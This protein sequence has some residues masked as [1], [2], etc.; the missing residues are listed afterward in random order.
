M[1]NTVRNLLCCALSSMALAAAA[2]VANAQVPSAQT[3]QAFPGRAEE[4][5]QHKTLVPRSVPGIEVKG[6]GTLNAPSGADK[7]SF[8]LGSLDLEGVTAYREGDL[9]PLYADK[10]GQKITLADLYGI[11]N[12]LT[13][14]YR[15]DGYILTQIVVPP[16]TIEGGTAKL[17][18]V[19]GFINRVDVRGDVNGIDFI[20]TIASQIK[21]GTKA[22]N[23]RQLERSLLIIN[24]LPGVTARSVLSPSKGQPGAA[25][26]LVIVERKPYDAQLG[27]DNYGTKYMGP[28]QAT[29]E[30]SLNSYF[31]LNEKITGQ[32]VVTP[33]FS[34][35]NELYYF[36]LDYEQPVWDRGTALELFANRTY[37]DPGY[38]L[39]QFDVHGRSAQW[40]AR[41][42]HPFIRTRNLSLFGRAGFDLRNVRTTNN[43]ETQRQDNIRAA[44]LGGR[45]EVLDSLLGAG[46]TAFN[47]LDAEVSRGLDVFG[48]SDGNDPNVSRPAA[49]ASFWKLNAEYQRL[50][51]LSPEVNLLLGVT[52]QMANEP[53]FA[54][55]EFGVGG[56]AYGRGYDPSEIL[57]DDGI[58]GKVELQWNEPYEVSM[59][60]DYQ[61]YSFYDIGHIW[62]QDA[63]VAG[64][65][66]E[67]AASFGFGMRADFNEVTN[68]SVML[69]FPL[70][71]PVA[72][73]GD[74]DARLFFSLNRKF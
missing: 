11:A 62:N 48:A 36:G 1:R 34:L 56:Q 41:L 14:K 27:I 38:D 58:S 50:Q 9:R 29:A 74:S 71:R 46:A 19:E 23:I 15:N 72:T 37:T 42:K 26:M 70:T 47:I 40:G 43:V 61:L 44:R 13:R 32:F 59:L 55:E 63:T 57:G 51:R 31:G 18:V 39:A 7:V 5:F 28:L 35:N 10:I 17:H 73:M 67:S 4:Q 6:S 64:Q 49:D 16:Q 25:D 20:R 22:V 21:T 24:D 3:G 52:G 2:S 65:G 53:L 69:A 30:G 45:F 66:Q 68:G 54:S 33:D 8:T 12:D 60:Q